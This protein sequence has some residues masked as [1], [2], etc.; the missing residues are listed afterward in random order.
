MQSK[1]NETKKG[2]G[3]KLK[4]RAWVDGKRMLYTPDY[5]HFDYAVTFTGKLIE[6]EWD[7]T[8]EYI[9]AELMQYTGLKDK[10][11]VEIYEGDVVSWPNDTVNDREIEEGISWVKYNTKSCRFDLG[12][13]SEFRNNYQGTMEFLSMVTPTVIGNIYENPELIK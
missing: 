6:N 3:R 13:P 2:S 11:G 7:G 1:E 12:W 10:N 5:D 8:T 9:K 4:F